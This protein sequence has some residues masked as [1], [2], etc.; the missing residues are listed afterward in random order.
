[1][2]INQMLNP[3]RSGPRRSADEEE[4]LALKALEFGQFIKSVLRRVGEHDA[5]HNLIKIFIGIQID[6]HTLAGRSSQ[7]ALPCKRRF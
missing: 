6:F 1:M 2:S 5:Q 4:L 7:C 3:G